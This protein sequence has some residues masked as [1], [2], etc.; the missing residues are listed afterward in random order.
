M[1]YNTTLEYSYYQKSIDASVIKFSKVSGNTW[2]ATI[3]D[4]STESS[5]LYFITAR[6]SSSEEKYPLVIKVKSN[7]D[8]T[9]VTECALDEG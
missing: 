8:L 9:Q 6:N 2:S 3:S 7:V 4:I 1:I 5:G